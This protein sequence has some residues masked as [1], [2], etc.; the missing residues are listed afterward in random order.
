M[1][2]LSLNIATKMMQIS[3]ESSLFA[4]MQPIFATFRCKFSK[5]SAIIRNFAVSFKCI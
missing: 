1:N 5:K 4:E 2:Q 3:A